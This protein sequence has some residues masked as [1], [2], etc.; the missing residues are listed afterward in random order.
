MMSIYRLNLGYIADRKMIEEKINNELEVIASMVKE[1]KAKR[2]VIDSTTAFGMWLNNEVL[3]SMLFKFTDS[4]KELNC[5]TLL[6]AETKGGK[7]DFSAYGV[8]EFVSD[9]VIALYFYPPHRSVFVRKMR[10]TNH[11]KNVHPFEISKK[12]I[13]VM[14]KETILWE[15]LK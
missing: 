7:A 9:G 4:L 8:E 14:P 3:R 2:L 15:A 10:G 5:T 1:I 6:T 12:G 11:N 13:E